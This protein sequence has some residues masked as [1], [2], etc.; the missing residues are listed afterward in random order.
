M[1]WKIKIIVSAIAFIGIAGIIGYGYVKI[2]TLESD[3]KVAQGQLNEAHNANLAWQKQQ[4]ERD[5]I[6]KQQLEQYKKMIA[7]Y[8]KN[9][10]E[11]REERKKVENNNVDKIIEK[12]PSLFSRTVNAST[13]RLFDELARDSEAFSSGAGRATTATTNTD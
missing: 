6:H 13:T 8:A 3:L 10:K 1:I 12:K 7:T 11:F 9:F 5:R 2:N 4:K